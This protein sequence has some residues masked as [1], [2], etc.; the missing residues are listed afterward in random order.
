MI[1]LADERDRAAEGERAEDEEG[2]SQPLRAAGDQHRAGNIGTPDQPDDA[3]E[4]DEPRD[5]LPVGRDEQ[6][7]RGRNEQRRDDHQ[8]PAEAEGTGAGIVFLQQ[9][10]GRRGIEQALCRPVFE[11]ALQ[12]APVH[13]F[14]LR[15]KMPAVR[16]D[17]GAV[18]RND[19][20][21]LEIR[22]RSKNPKKEHLFDTSA[23]E[24]GLGTT[25]INGK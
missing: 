10:P 4:P 1:H 22:N 14:L 2:G 25:K 23:L 11:V 12:P 8:N 17:S 24:D 6:Q 13:P 5:R 16:A 3:D 18:N 21:P 7:H 20:G 15:S 9:A 19:T